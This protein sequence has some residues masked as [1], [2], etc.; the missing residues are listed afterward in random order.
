MRRFWFFQTLCICLTL[1]SLTD[2]FWGGEKSRH[3]FLKIVLSTDFY[4]FSCLKAIK[5]DG[6]TNNEMNM[7]NSGDDSKFLKYRFRTSQITLFHWNVTAT[8]CDPHIIARANWLVIAAAHLDRVGELQFLLLLKKKF[9]VF[10][11]PF[12]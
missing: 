3:A 8:S 4:D 7:F 9:T 2:N 5:T 6:K 11:L 1:G 10:S 12:D